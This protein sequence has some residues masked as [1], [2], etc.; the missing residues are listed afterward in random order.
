M[1]KYNYWSTHFDLT[2]EVQ[3]KSAE[4]F[5]TQLRELGT[6]SHD[7]AKVAK[8]PDRKAEL[9]ERAKGFYQ[10]YLG[11]FHREARSVKIATNLADVDFNRGDYL[12]SASYYL[13]IFEGE[14]GPPAQKEILI[15]NAIL[16][17]Q[18]PSEYSFYE[19]LRSKGLL[20]RSIRSYQA[21]NPRK[22]PTPR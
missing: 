15:Q 12:N 5:E 19:Q 1:E 22:K 11:Y 20:V 8:A 17:L 10:L 16:A 9:F 21:F 7:L 18:K 6:K 4:F 13:R 14:F 3:K 2:P